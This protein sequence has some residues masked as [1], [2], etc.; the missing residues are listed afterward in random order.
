[1]AERNQNNGE[2]KN[3]GDRG[4]FGERSGGR[5]GFGG[6]EGGRAGRDGERRS[7]GGRDER[8]GREGERRNF[9]ENRENRDGQRREF[10]ENRGERSF[11]DR[12]RRDFG[13]R[14]RSGRDFKRDDRRGGFGSRDERGGER[15]SFGDRGDRGGERRSFRDER[16]GRDGE[17]RNFRE[18]RG[19]RGF[20]DRGGRDFKREDRRGGFSDRNERGGERRGF[21]DRTER[22][23]ERRNFRDNRGDRRDERFNRG[24]RDRSERFDKR[25]SFE[26]SADR[27]ARE[28][29]LLQEQLRPAR[30]ERKEPELPEEITLKDLHP[31]A[32]NELKTLDKDQAERVG[33]HL[34]AAGIFINFDPELAHEHA[35][36]AARRAGRIPVTHETLAI[37]SYTLG[38]FAGA[39]R[40]LRIYRRLTGRDNHIA[41][42][43]D[44]ERGLGRPEKALETARE[45]DI[46]TLQESE[47]VYLAIA[48][49][50]ARLDLEQPQ[51][52]LAELEIVQLNPNRAFSWSPELF[53]A[54]AA[55][56]EDLARTDEANR[57]YRLADRAEAAL[58]EH[59]GG[60]QLEVFDTEDP[61]APEF[62]DGVELD[63]ETEVATEE[64]AEGAET[65]SETTEAS[66]AG[67]KTTE[68]PDASAN[69]GE[70]ESDT[71]NGSA[72]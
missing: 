41:L 54:Y 7:F 34:A 46:A 19:E 45:A 51:Q 33:R 36:A 15:R 14:N 67:R 12:E 4:R 16:G 38:D 31:G 30:G 27:A 18:N 61:N 60:D 29:E 58:H 59:A 39:L 44:C 6:R 64:G 53:R 23:G 43:V 49:S 2:R 48:V 57:W 35:S 8:G 28:A 9:R 56:L 72:V 24:G 11:G 25:D 20:S 37:T 71:E 47:K 32:R 65:D 62:D 42:M 26:S 3:Y 22:S 68:T 50:G 1:M 5:S 52:A 40:E 55:V 10:R 66:A 17:R 21:G 63:G 13:D 70:T 69:D